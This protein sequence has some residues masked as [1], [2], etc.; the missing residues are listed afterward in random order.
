MEGSAKDPVNNVVA[1]DAAREFRMAS[2]VHLA[3]FLHWF[4]RTGGTGLLTNSR[5]NDFA[6]YGPPAGRDLTL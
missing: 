2:Q 6:L 5:F 3:L 1:A 4:S